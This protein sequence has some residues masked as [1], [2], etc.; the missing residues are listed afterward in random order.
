[1]INDESCN[2][3]SSKYTFIDIYSN[4]G[5]WDAGA[6]ASVQ[7]L[8]HERIFVEPCGSNLLEECNNASKLFVGSLHAATDLKNLKDMKVTHIITVT[9]LLD[10][11]IPDE[12]VDVVEYKRF[13]LIDHPGADLLAILPAAIDHLDHVFLQGG[14]KVVL[15]HCASGISRS[16]S[17]CC[18][19]FMVRTG[20]SF[21]FALRH[22]R[23]FRPLASPNAGF[24]VQLQLLQE[25]GNDLIRAR[26]I[27]LTRF[28]KESVVTLI[29]KQRNMA[30]ELHERIDTIENAIQIAAADRSDHKDMAVEWIGQLNSLINDIDEFYSTTNSSQF[31]D[32]P[33]R[34][35]ATSAMEKAVRFL[36][37]LEHME[38]ES[39]LV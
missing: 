9:S 34:M 39:K 26:D 27:Y 4:K 23:E 19:Y 17:V 36:S 13:D 16:V 6:V 28:Q 33:A 7:L 12:L 22:I 20:L 31:I 35:I 24:F 38:F 15:V 14:S 8:G 37:G 21:E 11:V 25:S 10:V 18:A 29:P 2:T 5:G 32:K 30:N 3:R 1:L